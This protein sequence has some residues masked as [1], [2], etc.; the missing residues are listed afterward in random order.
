MHDQRRITVLLRRGEPPKELDMTVCLNR[1]KDCCGFVRAMS[2]DVLNGGG[3]SL[4]I[5]N[6]CND[7]AMKHFA[8]ILMA[9]AGGDRSEP[10]HKRAK[11]DCDLPL[12][13]KE[14]IQLLESESAEVLMGILRIA[15]KWDF[16]AIEERVRGV[17]L[18]QLMSIDC[19]DLGVS[20]LRNE[21]WGQLAPGVRKAFMIAAASKLLEL[22]GIYGFDGWKSLHKIDMGSM[23]GEP[24][25]STAFEALA[26]KGAEAAM[27]VIDF[28]KSDAKLH[29]DE[30]PKY[31]NAKEIKEIKEAILRNAESRVRMFKTM[32]NSVSDRT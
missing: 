16:A 29:A 17:V 13:A 25:L 2:D 6:S 23:R 32:F 27:Q 31:Q 22:G 26:K 9:I 21:E 20:V 1:L 3:I 11:I 28:G 19:T 7:E 5:P 4:D 15:Q 24:W 18:Y 10:V 8:K 30:L 14:R 12:L